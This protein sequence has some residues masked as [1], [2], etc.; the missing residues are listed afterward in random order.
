MDSLAMLQEVLATGSDAAVIVCAGAI[1]RLDRRLLVVE[2][3]LRAAMEHIARA[4]SQ[5]VGE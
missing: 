5:R 4:W 3:R 2:E 1:W